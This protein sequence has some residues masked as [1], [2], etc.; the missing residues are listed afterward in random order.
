[1]TNLEELELYIESNMNELLTETL[2]AMRF[3]T[4][5]TI[6]AEKKKVLVSDAQKKE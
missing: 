2:I 5:D 6:E 1:M 3:A 4:K